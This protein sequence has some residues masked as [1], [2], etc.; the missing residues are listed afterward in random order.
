MGKHTFK[1]PDVMH[2]KATFKHQYILRAT[3]ITILLFLWC[4]GSNVQ[5]SSKD[6]S[7]SNIEASIYTRN[8]EH[9]HSTIVMMHG[10]NIQASSILFRGMGNHTSMH[11]GVMHG[12]ETLVVREETRIS[13]RFELKRWCLMCSGNLEL[14]RLEREDLSGKIEFVDRKS[15]V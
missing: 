8:N 10:A 9:H 12:K 14:I 6:A 15:V 1:H 13:V 4:M 11:P 2:G 5:A 7:D 3:S